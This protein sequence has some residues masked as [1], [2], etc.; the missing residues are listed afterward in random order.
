MNDLE[1]QLNAIAERQV[2]D[3][4]GLEALVRQT[5]TAQCSH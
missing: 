1:A 5:Y 2:R 4:A 3:P